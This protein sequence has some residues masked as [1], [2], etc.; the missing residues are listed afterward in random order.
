M[1]MA[2]PLKRRK[3]ITVALVISIILIERGSALLLLT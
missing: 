2:R 1:E 3:K